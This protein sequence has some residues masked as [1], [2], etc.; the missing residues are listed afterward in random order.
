MAVEGFAIKL[1]IIFEVMWAS[2]KEKPDEINK[3]SGSKRKFL[4]RSNREENG[5][6]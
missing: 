5:A 6:A 3:V 1:S 2:A 4:K